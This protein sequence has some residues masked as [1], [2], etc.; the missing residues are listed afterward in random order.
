MGYGLSPA[1]AELAAATG[2]KLLITVDSGIASN[3]GVA[4]AQSLGLRVLI[5][6][7][8]LAG[9]ELPAA[10]AIV[11]PNQPACGFASKNLAGVGVMFYLLLAVRAQLRADGA[12]AARAEPNLAELLDL[13][14]IGTV[15]DVVKLDRNNSILVQQGVARIRAGR[16]RPGVLALLRV[17]G[18][19]TSRQIGR[20]HV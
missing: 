13:V 2:A 5:T 9:S 7:H 20:A 18:R 10:E 12:F 19:E 11:N 4:H 6:D 14:A 17:A 8:H 3:D 16:A 15:A 1:L